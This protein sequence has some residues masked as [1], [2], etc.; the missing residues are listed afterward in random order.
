MCDWNA[1]VTQ[2]KHLRLHSTDIYQ[3][4]GYG[5]THQDI[6]TFNLHCLP[7]AFLPSLQW[8]LLIATI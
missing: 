3:T 6:L 7:A 2:E 4:D 8:F 1:T 5:F